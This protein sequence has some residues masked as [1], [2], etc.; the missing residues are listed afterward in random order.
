[1]NDV[2]KALLTGPE[3]LEL[4]AL[5]K[6]LKENDP[7]LTAPKLGNPYFMYDPENLI[8]LAEALKNNT[9]LTTLDLT[10]N[11]IGAKGA[12]ALAD[13][14]KNNKTL[15][16]LNLAYNKIGD[17]GDE[18]LQTLLV[19]ALEDNTTILE[20]DL[21]LTLFVRAFKK[22]DNIMKRNQQKL[23]EK[24]ESGLKEIDKKI[25]EYKKPIKETTEEATKEALN[26]IE[27][28][29]KN[30]QAKCE[31]LQTVKSADAEQLLH[32]LHKP[33]CELV[34]F[35]LGNHFHLE[36]IK[37][38]QDYFVV[39]P[40]KDVSLDLVTILLVSEENESSEVKKN[41]FSLIL[42][43][44]LTGV[45]IDTSIISRCYAAVEA[46]K[47]Y[48]LPMQTSLKPPNTDEIKALLNIKE[49]TNK[50]A[51]MQSLIAAIIKQLQPQEEQQP[52]QQQAAKENKSESSSTS[53]K[54]TTEQAAEKNLDHALISNPA[55][56]KEEEEPQKRDSNN[57]KSFFAKQEPQ[58]SPEKS[59]TLTN[60]SETQAD[61]SSSC[62]LI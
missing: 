10:D 37:L 9:T 49:D 56:K 27:N 48:T 53:P 43:L 32:K 33:Y 40:D 19:D 46:K 12:T 47:D 42:L 17:E 50:Q 52:L 13:M 38:Y 23:S 16:V 55:L 39:H 58:Y 25:A 1:M 30:L 26:D 60:F 41:K 7:M 20:I 59:S 11:H 62:N 14:L 5:I 29:L 45:P 51:S 18:G 34:Q 35:Y 21:E 28:S 31:A 2:L 3:N 24:I 36:F 4:K 22:N 61:E 6:R 57:A 15:T 8:A 54:V 44:K